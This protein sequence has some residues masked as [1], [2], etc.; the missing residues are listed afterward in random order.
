MKIQI[1]KLLNYENSNVLNCYILKYYKNSFNF[2]FKKTL[3]LDHITLGQVHI[4]TVKMAAKFEILSIS[5]YS[6]APG[7]AYD[8]SDRVCK[9]ADQVDRC[10]KLMDEEEAAGVFTC[11][12][13]SIRGIYR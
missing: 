6:C 5:R 7:L 12:N 1:F 9:W 8:P 3:H 2:D 13:T 11:P 4:S 10:K